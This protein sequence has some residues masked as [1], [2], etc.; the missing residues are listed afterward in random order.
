M[1]TQIKSISL[2][3]QNELMLRLCKLEQEAE[4]IKKFLGEFLQT[5]ETASCELGK[6]TKCKGSN[7]FVWTTEGKAAYERFKVEAG[8]N[9]LGHV[10]QGADS[11]RLTLNKH[12]PIIAPSIQAA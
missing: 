7:N 12:K 5:G 8:R 1:S 10:S 9:G 4:Q 2:P 6:L 11:L 3:V